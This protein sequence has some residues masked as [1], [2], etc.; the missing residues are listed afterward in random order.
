MAFWY[1]TYTLFKKRLVFAPKSTWK[2]PKGQPN[3]EDFLK[4]NWKEFV[5]LADTSFGYFNFSKEEW[6]AMRTL[7]NDKSMCSRLRSEYL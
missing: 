2:P 4:S 3:L 7:A 1:W 5:E 6:Q